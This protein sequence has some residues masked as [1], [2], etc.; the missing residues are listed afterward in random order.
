M[1]GVTAPNSDAKCLLFMQYASAMPCL[2]YQD[3][4]D[5]VDINVS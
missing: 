1:K 2:E 3:K 4:R 5:G